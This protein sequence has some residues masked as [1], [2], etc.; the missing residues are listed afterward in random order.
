MTIDYHITV[1][2]RLDSDDK[3]KI[4]A[5]ID[6]TFAEIDS[7]YNKWNPNSEISKLNRLK[8]YE[9]VILSDS[10]FQFLKRIDQ[11]VV[12]SEGR[13]DPTVE[14]LGQLWK[15]GIP[16]QKEINDLKPCIGWD[17][18]HFD[19]GIFFKDDAR[20]ALD[21]GGVA[22][23]YAVDLLVERIAEAGFNHVLV[24]WGGE[25]RALGHHPEGRPWTVFISRLGDPDPARSLDIIPLQ[26]QALATSG[27]YFQQWT[28]QL[29]DG[30]MHTYCHIFDP[31]T[32]GPLEVKK[33]SIASASLLADDCLTAD[34]FAKTFMLCGSKEEAEIWG[35]QLQSKLKNSSYWLLI[36]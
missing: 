28:I 29:D 10:L 16:S 23:G 30:S 8:A 12:F 26:D 34:A 15:K 19:N 13:F 36:N 14:P 2:H 1:G 11:F 18:I 3:K 21:F 9:K 35:E 32:W 17:K 7:I 4:Q 6:R 31:K 27:D 5:I 25:M 20:T 24:E 33:G 22:K